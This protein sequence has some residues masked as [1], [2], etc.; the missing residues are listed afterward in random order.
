MKLSYKKSPVAF[1]LLCLLL[2]FI[3]AK[4]GG[5]DKEWKPI[6]PTDLALKEPKVEK[7]ADAEAIFWEVKVDDSK[8]GELGLKHYIR[9]KVF[10]E[11]GREKYSKVEIPFLKGIKIKDVAARVIKPDGTIVEI[12]K[13]EIVEKSIINSK[14]LKLKA[15]SFAVP[16]LEPGV[17]FEYRY[18]QIIDDA[19]AS[20]MQLVFQRDI[21]AQNITY[22]I[23]PFN[24]GLFSSMRTK[25][26]NFPD[27]SFDDKDKEGYYRA[28]KTNIPAY[29]EEPY[30]P[31]EDMVRYWALLTST[32]IFGDYWWD[33]TMR[34]S[35]IH[36]LMKPNNEIKKL[37]PQIISGA[38][39]PEEK[40]NRIFDF[41]RKEIRNLSYDFTMSAEQKNK[42]KENKNPGDTL[43]NKMG[44]IIDIELLFASMVKEAGFSVRLAMTG[45]RSEFFFTPQDTHQRFIHIACI[46]VK[47][48]DE[49]KYYNPGSLYVQRGMLV[50]Y[51]EDE[52]ALLIGDG[53]YS[54]GKTP[55]SG[56]EK[57]LEKRKGRFKLLEDGTLEG[58]VSIE[59]TGHLAQTKRSANDEASQSQREDNL[60]EAVKKK[61][62]AA[63]I[64]DIRVENVQDSDKPFVYQYKVRIPGYASKV[65]KRLFLQPGVFEYGS[66]PVFSTEKR[67]HSIYFNYPWSE[68]DDIEITLP[69][70]FALDNADT[71]AP[72]S[73]TNKIINLEIKMGV[74]ADKSMLVYKRKFYVG[75]GGHILFPA[76]A[77][78]VLKALFDGIQKADT[79]QITLKQN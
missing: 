53:T 54:W 62:S 39:T 1:V 75:K 78:S 65:G 33:I 55:L 45:D 74:T 23:K 56:P 15:L 57:S 17:I 28:T 32:S 37:V 77:Y 12:G 4:A 9:V 71:P 58:E 36:E 49:W 59:Y 31:P 40:V 68:E 2:N 13:N 24:G 30:M 51:E 69:Q 19:G 46:A 50:W 5:D 16:G 61:I 63:E 79:H 25:S 11:R 8:R 7:D 52:N 47:V 27:I 48:N 3:T 14:G 73:D 72:I 38:A 43:K 18:K 60:K 10:T 42:I 26:Y 44:G 67:Q 21:P 66:N 20:G 6:D 76:T 35:G 64:S 34:Y 41:C 29:K 70:G 22:Y